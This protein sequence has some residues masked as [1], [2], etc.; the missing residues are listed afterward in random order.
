MAVTL[1]PAWP[2]EAEDLT[3]PSPGSRFPP[4]C[5]VTVG[6]RALLEGPGVLTVWGAVLGATVREGHRSPTS[7]VYPRTPRPRL[8]RSGLP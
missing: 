5:E 8:V 7:P 4:G 1:S 2:L 3:V 6:G